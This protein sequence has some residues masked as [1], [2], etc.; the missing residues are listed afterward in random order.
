MA[1]ETPAAP[2]A[3]AAFETFRLERCLTFDIVKPPYKDR[4]RRLSPPL[5]PARMCARVRVKSKTL[6]FS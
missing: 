3:T 6:D 4:S 5:R 1:K 2:N